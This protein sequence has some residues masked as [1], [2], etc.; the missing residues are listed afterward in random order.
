MLSKFD[1]YGNWP[2]HDQGHIRYEVSTSTWNDLETQKSSERRDVPYPAWCS[3]WQSLKAKSKQADTENRLPPSAK[4]RQKKKPEQIKTLWA[5]R[6]KS[7]KFE[8]KDGY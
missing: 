2:P 3:V 5:T 4:L 1:L 6:L 7:K 8:K